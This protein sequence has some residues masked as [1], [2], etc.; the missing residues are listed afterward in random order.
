MVRH[1]DQLLGEDAVLVRELRE[2]VGRLGVCDEDGAALS[3]EAAVQLGVT[4]PSSALEKL[5][6]TNIGWSDRSMMSRRRTLPSFS[7]SRQALGVIPVGSRPSST[8][9]VLSVV[10]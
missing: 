4:T 9:V 3:V 10:R 6:P 8:N 1:S 2:V 5:V 7:S